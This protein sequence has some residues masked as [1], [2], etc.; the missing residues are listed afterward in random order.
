M[1]AKTTHSYPDKSLAARR[2]QSVIEAM[3]EK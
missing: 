3:Y 2:A 1:V